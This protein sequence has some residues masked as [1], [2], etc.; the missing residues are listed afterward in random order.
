MATPSAEVDAR[1][2]KVCSKPTEKSV[3]RSN[4]GLACPQDKKGHLQLLDL[5]LDILK[6]IVKE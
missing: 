1:V 5:P 3:D 4:P 6:D 2:S